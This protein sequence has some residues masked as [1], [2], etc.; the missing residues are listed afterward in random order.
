MSLEL[1][2]RDSQFAS[3]CGQSYN[4][5]TVELSTTDTEGQKELD[6]R[7]KQKWCWCSEK[8]YV[9]SSWQFCSSYFPIPS[10]GT[11]L[12]LPV[13]SIGRHVTHFTPRNESTNRKSTDSEWSKKGQKNPL[14]LI[15]NNSAKQLNDMVSVWEDKKVSEMVSGDGCKPMW[16][17]LAL[18]NCTLQNG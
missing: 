13:G 5:E 12:L 9:L 17:Y 16:V 8:W 2:F 7:Q 1:Q 11:A 18:L 6:H 3:A 15:S 4:L 14:G 10:R